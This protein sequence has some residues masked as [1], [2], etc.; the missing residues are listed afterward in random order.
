MGELARYLQDVIAREIPA[1]WNARVEGRF[2]SAAI[3][4]QY[5]FSPC[6]D[7]LLEADGHRVVVE[8]E[9]SRADPVA[10]HVKFLLAREAGDLTDKDIF[11]SMMS[12]HI[13]R[14]RRAQEEAGRLLSVIEPRG[15]RRHRIHFA[16]DV[17]DVVANLWAWNN[18]VHGSGWGRRRVQYFV[19]D[20]GSGNF[21]PSKFCA[22][23]P[24]PL[25]MEATPPT[26]TLEIYADLGEQDARFD[27]HIARKHLIERLGF[28]EV[29][30]TGA[31][32]RRFAGW[33]ATLGGAL[34]L[35]APVRALLPPD[36]YR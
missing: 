3:A 34:T 16:G 23:I 11:V 9:I 31:L 5:G 8:L 24:A 26:M 21:A 10:N 13:A 14:G 22:F 6:A 2:L 19:F 15:T 18:G 33:M 17:A 29:P 25:G 20:P 12:P 28:K 7:L 32:E 1:R 36:W 35:R 27:G 30:M 4:G